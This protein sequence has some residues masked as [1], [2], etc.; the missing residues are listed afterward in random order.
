MGWK[1]RIREKNFL[2]RKR[3]FQI[4]KYALCLYGRFNNRYS[5]SAGIE[6]FEYLKE[7]L[8]KRFNFDTFIFSND[9]KNQLNIEERYNNFATA[10]VIEQP[11]DWERSEYFENVNLSRFKPKQG[12]RK[13]SDTINF[14]YSR[15]E[16]IKL[17]INNSKKQNKEYEWIICCRFDSAQIDKHNGYQPFKVSQINFN[18]LLEKDYLYTALWNQTNAGLADQWIYGS[19]ENISRLVGMHEKCIRY[20]ESDSSYLKSLKLGI[21]LSNETDEFS[22]EILHPYRK[23]SVIPR[24]LPE[25]DA[26]DNHLIHK[27]FFLENNLLHKNKMVAIIP[28]SARVLY[29]HTDYSDCWPIYFGQV[30]KIGNL[31][32][33]NYVLV[34][35]I[36]HRIPTYFEQIVYDEN[37]AYTDRLRTSLKH[38]D[39][40]VIF[41]EHEDMILYDVPE[42]TQLIAYVD[43]IKK[44][45][46]D[47][48]NPNR[49][50]S[51][52]L[53]RGGKFFSR[54][55]RKRGINSLRA[56]SRLSPW[57]FS[58]QPSFWLKDSLMELLSQHK[59]K[60]IWKFEKDA[61]KTMRVFRFRVATVFEKTS[62]R[63]TYHFNS[64][65]YPFI[66]TA[67]V[68]GKWNTLEYD[69][70]LTELSAEF[71]VNLNLRGTNQ[72]VRQV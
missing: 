46:L 66:A 28:G 12:F 43:L 23:G 26:I 25:F 24:S 61:Q 2:N 27:F 20:F 41:F 50:D 54:K 60:P 34:D 22:N 68:K 56:I 15:S 38:V 58:I 40:N 19:Q 8:Y 18:P 37:L 71:R 3:R 65:I 9:V 51:I 7:T 72:L 39:S 48:F 10:T 49:F 29:T 21:P 62:K 11:I 69:E 1:S 36:D 57:I 30:D 55:V 42:V 13:L 67:I 44:N 45:R 14:L 32:E 35:K 70:E 31:F 59:E 16:S 63:G 64:R 47:F 4:Q 33:K 5:E 17:A 52:K 53:V 6:G